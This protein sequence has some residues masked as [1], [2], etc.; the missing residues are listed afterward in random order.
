LIIKAFLAF[1]ILKASL[2]LRVSITLI[3]QPD[4]GVSHV[5]VNERN[6]PFESNLISL[7]SGEVK[8]AGGGLLLAALWRLSGSLRTGILVSHMTALDSVLNTRNLAQRSVISFF[9]E[10]AD[11]L[12]RRLSAKATNLPSGEHAR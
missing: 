4:F 5:V 11:R 6:W 10:S 1:S 8:D 2:N 3:V 9:P 12:L 7:Y